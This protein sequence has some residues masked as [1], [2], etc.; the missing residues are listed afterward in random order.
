MEQWDGQEYRCH[1]EVDQTDV[2][3]PVTGE[4]LQGAQYGGDEGGNPRRN[5]QD[6]LW[7]G[8]G[9]GP[10]LVAGRGT[11]LE[12]F[13]V[14][15]PEGQF[16]KYPSSAS[17]L[18]PHGPRV[19]PNVTNMT[20]FFSVTVR[21]ATLSVD[22]SAPPERVWE[23]V[24]DI[25]LMPRFST[26]LQSTAWADGFRTPEIG[27]QFLGT[28]RHPA[29]GEWTTTSRI[30]V[31]EPPLMFG[32]VVG[33]PENPAAAWQFELRPMPGGTRLSYTA[34][35]GPGPSGVSMLIER[36]PERAEEIFE[37]RLTQFRAGMQATLAGIQEMAEG[38]PV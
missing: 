30:V 20:K 23:L 13:T 26:E 28:N 7:T 2:Q 38:L 19:T 9:V 29:I 32:W 11:A 27:A 34:Q 14:R 12:P 4:R 33:N 3:H 6:P 25:T 16:R 17:P 24:T 5:V 37:R 21:E 8:D 22:I 10:M 31:C 35:I 18:G 15:P 1:S 36:E